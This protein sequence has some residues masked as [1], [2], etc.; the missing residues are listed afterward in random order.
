[1]HN[2][3]LV[4]LGIDAVYMAFDVTPDRLAEVVP[5]MRDMGFGGI[6]LTVPLK[7]AA[8]DIVDGID[9]HAKRLG[10]V[11]T[12][13]FP[14]NGIVKGHNTDGYGFLRALA[15]EF[16]VDPEGN[17]VFVLGC[18][19]AG[20]GVALTCAERGAR[21]LLLASRNVDRAKVVGEEARREFKDC[22]VEVVASEPSA[23]SVA[24][25]DADIVVQCTLVGMEPTDDSLLPR[26]AF[27]EGQVVYDL[28]Y[29][30]PETAFMQAARE[31]GARVANGLGM[32]LHQG[33]K[34]FEIWTGRKADTDA[35]RGALEAAVYGTC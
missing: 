21:R 13:E 1:M 4:S 6:N 29:L 30:H 25:R 32:L 15:E 31:G 33:A 7:E 24:C 19:G 18:G 2:A 11:N 28:V 3:S 22:D 8:V 9:S 14:A 17:S 26:D 20:R 35:M 5:A 34:S 27:R 23:W 12:V 16:G 10:A